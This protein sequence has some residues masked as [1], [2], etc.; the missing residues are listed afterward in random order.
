MSGRLLMMVVIVSTLFLGACQNEKDKHSPVVL[1]VADRSVSLDEFRS[2]FD[3]IVPDQKSLSDEEIDELERSFLRQII[4]RELTLAEADRVGISVS[5]AE[6]ERQVHEYRQEYP[7]NE[8][9][10][11]LQ[12]QGLTLAQWRR[13]LKERLLQEKVIEKQV[14]NQ[15]SVDDSEIATYYQDNRDEFDRPE[16]VRARQILLASKEQGEKVLGL[17]RQGER[18][19]DIAR[20][21]SLS[22]D[23]EKG[24]DLG[25]F[26]RGEMPP[27]FDEVVFALTPGRLSDLIKTDYGYHVFRVEEKRPAERLEL[28]E[29]RDQIRAR[30]LE[31][32]EET[33]YQKWLLG[34]S[35]QATIEV[36]WALLNKRDQKGRQ[37]D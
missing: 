12:Q 15:L 23:S 14:Y 2:D 36:D 25:F 7:E 31:E 20:Q 17:L 26:A 29:V 21:F 37:K 9:G 32:K 19:E 16:Q 11:M 22:P 8:F 5:S 4:D 35:G 28:E 18:F 30:L 34:L 33:A 3:Q 24:G 10:R 27:Q 13:D 1:K 6:L